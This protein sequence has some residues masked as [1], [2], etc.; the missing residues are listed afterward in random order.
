MSVRSKSHHSLEDSAGSEDL[1]SNE[2]TIES[3]PRPKSILKAA[4]PHLPSVSTLQGSDSEAV[5]PRISKGLRDRLAADDAEI[6]ALE[7]ALGVKG[8]DLTKTFEDDGLGDLLDNLD[9]EWPAPGKRKRTGEDE[10]L[11]QKR[12]KARQLHAAP[13]QDENH[14]GVRS[15][16]TESYG[17]ASQNEEVLDSG[18]YQGTEQ[19]SFDGFESESEVVDKRPSRTRE[20]PYVAPLTT[21]TH[22]ASTSTK[23]VPPSMRVAQIG[24]TENLSRLRRQIQGLLNRL[25]EA[26]IL[27]ILNDVEKLYREH[28]RQHVATTLI[29]L[30]VGLLNDPTSLQDTFIILH[31]GFIAAIYKV[32][33]TDFGAQV[34]QRVVEEFDNIHTTKITGDSKGKNSTNLISLLAELYNFQ[35]IGSGLVYDFIR[36]FLQDLSESNTELLLK[37]IRSRLPRRLSRIVLTIC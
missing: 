17:N 11:E 12:R 16:G 19:A 14:P 6:E 25:S 10:W 22:N 2:S 8:K 9:G 28:P 15:E 29:D 36:I 1:T 7:R 31:A 5:Q 3:V 32:V 26:N 4:K 13:G 23:Y 24:E 27:S 33:G 30:L 21:G 20:N 37:V 18:E 34:V 35:V